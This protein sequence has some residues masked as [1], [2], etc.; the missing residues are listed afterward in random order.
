MSQLRAWGALTLAVAVLVAPAA[1]ASTIL[2]IG[3]VDGDASGD[4]SN[5]AVAAADAAMIA[6][7]SS[8]GFNVV[9]LDDGVATP[10]DLMGISAVFIS[11]S[12]ASGPIRDGWDGTGHDGM[13]PNNAALLRDLALPVILCENGLSDELGF[14][15]ETVSGQG[16]Y[17]TNGVM[18]VLLPSHP[19]AVAAG[20]A[21]GPTS[22]LTA[23]GPMTGFANDIFFGSPRTAPGFDIVATFEATAFPGLPFSAWIMADPGDPIGGNGSG[24]AFLAPSIRIGLPLATTTFTNLNAQGLAM[25]DAAIR[26]AIPEP[27]T[28]TLGILG[29]WGLAWTARR[30]RTN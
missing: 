4:G 7:I 13:G 24:G 1:S 18:N 19:M 2:F 5:P 17:P 29:L 22:M 14:A 16:E 9:A 21:G 10:A 20:L 8:L 25:F 11:A 26:T 30:R 3:D 15:T 27:A 6:R 23:A 28:W 12:S